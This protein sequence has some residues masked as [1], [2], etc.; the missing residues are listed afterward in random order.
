HVFADVE[1]SGASEVVRNWDQ[2]KAAERQ[3]LPKPAS[4]LDGVPMS[5][6]Q[7]KRSSELARKANKAALDWPTRDGTLATVR[8]ELH[9]LLAWA[10]VAEKREE[11]GELLYVLAKLA[12][13][14]GIDPEE[15]RR[16][17]N[18]KFTERFAALE[19]IARERGWDTL[20]DRPL[21]DLESAWSEA[22]RRVAAPTGP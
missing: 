10:R 2:L 5:L 14:D 19:Q 11:L 18:R 8:E 17:A 4:A 12:S 6:P 16:A 13:Q 1:V 21:E 22:K 9:E 20:R 3:H 7:L 15:A